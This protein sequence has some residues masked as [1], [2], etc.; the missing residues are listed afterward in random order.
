MDR[1]GGVNQQ[2]GSEYPGTAGKTHANN[3]IN[4]MFYVHICI[5][6]VKTISMIARRGRQQ[7]RVVLVIQRLLRVGTCSGRHERGLQNGTEH[8]GKCP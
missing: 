4:Y 3:F 6:L 1:C 2:A 7:S 8:V 5:L